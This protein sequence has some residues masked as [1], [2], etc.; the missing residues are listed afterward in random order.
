MRPFIP[1]GIAAGILSALLALLP[2]AG[3]SVLALPLAFV[4]PLPI[5]V[6]GFA[7]GSASAAIGAL[8]LGA[9]I[10]AA[11]DLGSGTVAF[12][13]VGV[14]IAVIVHYFGLSRPSGPG[15][16]TQ[17]FPLGPILLRVAAVVAVGT[18]IAGLI[19]GFDA[20]A[21]ATALRSDLTLLLQESGTATDELA[22][23]TFVDGL[24]AALPV[25]VAASS[26]VIAVANAFIGASVAAGL[27][28]TVRPRP[29]AWT[30]GLPRAASIAF[31][32]AALATFIPGAIGD[33]A[34][35]VA[36]AFGAALVLVGLGIIH[37]F[38][39]RIG[40]RPLVLFLVYASMPLFVWIPALFYA[41]LAILDTVTPLRPQTDAAGPTTRT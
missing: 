8:A 18:V 38:T 35:A 10:A 14:P 19:A 21:V 39:R 30:V 27:G 20:D 2:I 40:A 13:T 31:I 3:G 37:A 1:A 33:A 24:V 12:L 28:Y 23:S 32:I 15:G 16:T 34:K 26:V 11:G 4:A 9:A 25:A 5:A 36:G 22:V 29:A 17:W 6:A 41:A 7:Y